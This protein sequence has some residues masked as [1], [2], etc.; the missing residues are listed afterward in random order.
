VEGGAGVQTYAEKGI[1]ELALC[2]SD[3]A[4]REALLHKGDGRLY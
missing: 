1:A 4:V 2:G 3:F